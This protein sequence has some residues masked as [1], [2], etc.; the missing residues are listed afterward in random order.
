MRKKK[1]F[2]SIIILTTALMLLLVAVFSA[3]GELPEE[4]SSE[5]KKD[6]YSTY[7]ELKLAFAASDDTYAIQMYIDDLAK[8]QGLE[9]KNS[10]EGKLIVT[11]P[12]AVEYKNYPTIIIQS[13]LSKVNYKECAQAAAI[14]LNAVKAARNCGDIKIIFTSEKDGDMFGARAVQAKELNSDYLLSLDYNKKNRVYDEGVAVKHDRYDKQISLIKAEGDKAYEISINGLPEDNSSEI[15]VKY[16]N[17]II[18]LSN[19]ISNSQSAGMVINMAE[20]NGGNNNIQSRPTSAKIVV[21]MDD[22]TAEKFL[23]RVETAK[24]IFE[25]KQTD[26]E[27]D[28]EASFYFKEVKM[29]TR[30]INIQDTKDILSLVYAIEDGT[31]VSTVQGEKDEIYTTAVSSINKISTQGYFELAVIGR[32]F[33]KEILSN[34]FSEYK[35][36][37]KLLKINADTVAQTPVWKKNSNNDLKKYEKIV[38]D[39]C[40]RANVDVKVD[41]TYRATEISYFLQKNQNIRPLVLT[42]SNENSFQNTESL[43]FLFQEIQ[44]VI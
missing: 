43:V 15:N 9:T 8:K 1:R 17:P 26:Y 44:K 41:S 2:Q 30:M 39:S 19:I 18:F 4:I 29:P 35:L 40:K 38:K 25:E 10:K 42:V 23:N 27:I 24:K 31:Y 36:A 33:N 12:A 14:S 21:T 20:F 22:I 16:V 32:S 5:M 7:E 13:S 34:M 11:K 3:C 6:V 28:S 37:A